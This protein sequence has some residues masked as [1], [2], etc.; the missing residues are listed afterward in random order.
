MCPQLKTKK[1]VSLRLESKA[2]LTLHANMKSA[3]LLLSLYPLGALKFSNRNFFKGEFSR[4]DF[5]SNPPNECV[6]EC[7]R[8]S[9]VSRIKGM[10]L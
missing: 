2:Y 7:F 1:N 6:M 5:L 10:I 3:F 8:R 4:G 9:T